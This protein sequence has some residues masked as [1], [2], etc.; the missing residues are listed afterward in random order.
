MDATPGNSSFPEDPAELDKFADEPE[1][2]GGTDLV[3][4]YV[5]LSAYVVIITVGLLGNITLVKIFISN[6]AMRSVP[7]IF[8]SSLAAGDL[9]LLVTCVPVDAF[10]YF[11]EEWIFGTVA[12]KLIPVIQLT[13]VGV[14]V[15]TLTALSADRYKAIVNPMDIQTSSA[16]LWTCLKA[17]SIWLV[18]VL[19]AVPEAIFSQVVHIQDKNVT[20]TACVPYPLSNEMHPKIHSVLIFLVY[21]LIPLGI[22][23]VYYY[24]IA[25][26]LIKSAHDMPGEISEHSKRQMETRKR[27]AKIVLVFV[28]L[29]A[30]CW[31]PNHVLYMYRSFNY[32]HIDS[33]LS[34]F[35]I[36]L[37]ARVLS[38]SSS[39][40]NPF[41][42]YMLSESFRRHFN[43]QLRCQRKPYHE[44]NASFLQST[45]AV[46][47]TS[48]KKNP[49][50]AN[51]HGTR[52]EVSL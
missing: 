47:M 30:L 9:L 2:D 25:R 52:Q 12:C 1:P 51:G 26:T 18:S 3:M 36:T 19:L 48:I 40:V 4:R 43:S 17:V 10:R 22:I 28:G 29:F 8:I 41:A 11:F 27:L 45:S 39:C 34:H 33:S 49:P 32:R 31:F 6:S 42:L 5:I 46:R 23:S 14:S 35:I 15:F 20:F 38:F 44:R 7:N 13:S 16:V 50:A 24:H 37:L 21:F